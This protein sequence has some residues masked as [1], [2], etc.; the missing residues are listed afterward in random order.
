MKD[1]L[2]IFFLRK[3]YTSNWKNNM[4]NKICL[5]SRKFS[6][7]SGSGEWIFAAKL[8][9]AL[10]EGGFNVF[11]IEEGKSGLKSSRYKKIFHDWIRIP[12]K[13][14][15]YYFSG[16]RKFHFLSEN[17]ATCIPLLNLLRADT[18]VTFHDLMRIDGGKTGGDRNYFKFIYWLAS[19]AKKIHCNSQATK[20]DLEDNFGSKENAVVISVNCRDFSPKKEKEFKNIIGYLGALNHRKRPEKILELEK[21]MLKD[22]LK[23]KI[24]IWGKGEMFDFMNKN[25]GSITTMKGFA[26]EKDLEKI[27]NSFDFFIFP[28]SYEGLGMPIIESA[29]CGVPIF[30]YADAKITPEVKA[31]CVSCSNSDD[32]FKKIKFFKENPKEYFALK[33]KILS[34]SKKFSFEKSIKKLTILYNFK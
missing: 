5:I 9:E 10:A 18:I 12:S 19:R 33:D 23:C 24:H 21:I 11:S 17:Q 27:F 25:R 26:P 8:R 4:G 14:L 29:M 32:I 3:S 16:V 13:C 20:K 2:D 34:Q 6:E 7:E 22:S 15:Y 28:T 30:V 1:F 31:L